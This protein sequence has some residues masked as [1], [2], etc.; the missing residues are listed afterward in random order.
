M[1][2]RIDE[3][4]EG[5]LT[6]LKAFSILP[7]EPGKPTHPAVPAI[8]ADTITRH[9]EKIDPK[10]RQDYFERAIAHFDQLDQ[11]GDLYAET[12]RRAAAQLATGVSVSRSVSRVSTSSCHRLMAGPSLW[13]FRQL[14]DIRGAALCLIAGSAILGLKQ[15]LCCPQLNI[16]NEMREAYRPPRFISRSV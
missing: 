4:I 14:G 9:T 5:L 13:Q 8:I 11:Q 2:D 10:L 6:E 16:A 3:W 12:L 7:R 15:S 1:N